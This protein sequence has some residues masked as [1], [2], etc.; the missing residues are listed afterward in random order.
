VKL[1]TGGGFF[2]VTSRAKLTADPERSIP[3]YYTSFE[4]VSAKD[5][6]LESLI[7]ISHPMAELSKKPH[8]GNDIGDFQLKR[9]ETYLGTAEKYH[10]TL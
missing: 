6:S 7:D 2:S 1:S 8:F 3:T 9:L 5:V 10:H 4:A